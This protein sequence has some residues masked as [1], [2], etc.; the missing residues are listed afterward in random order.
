MNKFDEMIYGLRQDTKVPESVW[1]KYTDTLSKLPDKPEKRGAGNRRWMKYAASAAAVVIVGSAVCCANPALAAK[2][3]FIGRIFEEVQQIATFSGEYDGKSEVLPEEYSAENAGVTVTASEIYCDGLS[4][5]LTAEVDVAQGGLKN[6][7]GKTVY[8]NGSWRTGADGK[9]KMLANN[10]LEGKVIDDRTF[11]GMLKLD[12]EDTDLKNGTL[13]LDI[14]MV[15]Y[16]DI[17]E[18]DLEDIT[19]SHTIKGEWTLK[20][21]FSADTEAVK[22]VQVNQENEGYCLR[23]VFVSPYQVIAYTD[24]PYTENTLTREEFDEMMRKE[25]TGGADPGLTYEQYMEQAGKDCAQCDTIIF[26][27]DGEMLQ[28]A[29]EHHGRAVCAVQEKEISKLYIYVFD[30]FDT[31]AEVSEK[32]MECEAA[33]QALISAEVDVK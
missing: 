6:L 7:P 28:P 30:D 22:T 29:E 23:E 15:G 33:G 5:F 19:A 11:I 14:S 9:E 21:P 10:N 2:I 27:Q 4:V 26:N 17:N 1:M 32:G 20:L 13:E 8:L 3:P 16:D 18:L 25:K 31:W 12:L 24:V